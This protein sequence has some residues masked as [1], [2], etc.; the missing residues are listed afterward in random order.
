[1]ALPSYRVLN[2]A[3]IHKECWRN[4]GGMTRQIASGDGWRISLATIAFNGRFSAFSGTHRQSILL[5]G[6]PIELCALNHHVLLQR[7]TVTQYRGDL[8][9]ECK[10]Q[11][12]Q[13]SVLNV[14]C[15][16]ARATATLE[17]GRELSSND[18]GS[19]SALL[20]INCS[21]KCVNHTS[22]LSVVVPHGHA[23]LSN[24]NDVSWSCSVLSDSE[25]PSSSSLIRIHIQLSETPADQQSND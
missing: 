2:I 4:G 6:D 17:L 11:G 1:M 3:D 24:A 9:W 21:A 16:P 25:T 14:I 20:P 13:A 19:F 10:L 8:A 5:Q 7:S 18:S 22:N 15:E 12:A 23:L